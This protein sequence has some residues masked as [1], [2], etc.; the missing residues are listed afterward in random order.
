MS[1]SPGFIVAIDGPA[2]S[3]KSTTARL[4]AARL[5]FRHL[6]T[7]AMY[8][9][10]TLKVIE[11]DT[12]SHSRRA[13]SRMLAETKVRVEWRKSEAGTGRVLLDGRDVSKA[14]RAPEVSRWA[15]VVSAVP[16][17]RRMMVREQRRAVK[18]QNVVCEGRD[19]GSVVFPYAQL[20]VY[21]DCDIAVRA[22]R[23]EKELQELGTRQ[24]YRSVRCGL[25]RRDRIDSTRRMSPLKRVNDAVLID[26]TDLTIEEQV[27][28]VCDLAW[29]RGA[30]FQS[31]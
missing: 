28:I 9:A 22:R 21:L 23:R 11:T 4:A 5:G 3:G 2:G 12:D 24:S 18:G 13:L 17:V 7:G 29:R 8:R 1:R 30:P 27:G 16:L 19:I 6:D 10:V 15:S 20:K 31:G 14:I 25:V 26:T